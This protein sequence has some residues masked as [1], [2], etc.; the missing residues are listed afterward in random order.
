MTFTHT[1]DPDD[2]PEIRKL[3]LFTACTTITTQS[4][5]LL[6]SRPGSLLGAAGPSLPKLCTCLLVILIVLVVALE[7]ARALVVHLTAKRGD[8][9]EVERGEE[10]VEPA[11]VGRIGMVDGVAVSEEDAHAGHL[12]LEKPLAAL[13]DLVLV[14]VVILARPDGFV[15]GDLEVEVEV[16]AVAR[17][18]GEL[19]A[20]LVLVGRDLV[21][22]AAG[23]STEGRGLGAEVAR[24]G[25]TAI[26]QWLA[27]ETPAGTG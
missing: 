3:F 12:A 25:E 13:Q 23:D 24:V 11:G 8:V 18:P 14:L 20:R 21:D 7:A 1:R 10:A 17:H 6:L 5:H 4:A 22:G 16:A 9:E 2:H 19:P 15:Q 27:V 26:G